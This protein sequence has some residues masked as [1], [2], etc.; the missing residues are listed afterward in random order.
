MGRLFNGRFWMDGRFWTLA[1]GAT[2]VLWFIAVS[3]DLDVAA[4][5][6]LHLMKGAGLGVMLIALHGLSGLIDD[7]VTEDASGEPAPVPIVEYPAAGLS[8]RDVLQRVVHL[9]ASRPEQSARVV[10]GWLSEPPGAARTPHVRGKRGDPA[11]S[12]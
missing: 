7:R 11:I 6:T 4:A 5:A 2:V 10:R 9:I 8:H 12:D 1:A 3:M